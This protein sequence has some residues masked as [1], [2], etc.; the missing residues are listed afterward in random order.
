MPHA[1][2]CFDA[3]GHA[4]F[5]RD[6]EA[7]GE[8][9]GVWDPVSRLDKVIKRILR[10]VKPFI[11]FLCFRGSKIQGSKIVTLHGEPGTLTL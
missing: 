9:R 4:I 2:C 1:P 6:G 5:R 11:Q 10:L 7:S 8:W 3:M